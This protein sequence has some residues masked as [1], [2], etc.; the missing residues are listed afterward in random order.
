MKTLLAIDIGSYKTTAIIAEQNESSL[1]ISG[2]G[3]AKSRGI[4][5]GAIINIDEAAK[6]IKKA[7]SD[8]ER[9]AGIE[10]KEAI[11]S[12]SSTY[13]KSI[14]SHGIV[15]IPKN[16]ITKE[17]IDRVIQTA[18]Y[19]ATNPADYD[20]L[21]AIPYNFKVDNQTEI[22]DP[23]GM[24]GSRLEVDLHIIIAQ[25]NGIENIKK[26]FQ[27]AGIEI[28]A[29]VNSAYASSLAVLEEDEKELGVALIDIG[30]TTSD[31]AIFINKTIRYVDF[32]GIGS[33]HITND[34][35]IALHT[36][37]ADAEYIKVNF[38]ELIKENREYIEI[39]MIGS[40][41]K[42]KIS[43]ATIIQIMSARIEETFL[44]LNKEIDNSGNKHQING[45]VL[46]G[47]FTNFYN[48]REIASQFFDGLP[49]RVG[50]PKY[51]E[52]SF[53]KLQNPESSAVIGLLLYAIGENSK[54]ET[55][56]SKV[57]KKKKV[58]EVIVK[59]EKEEDVTDIFE[60][61]PSKKKEEV[62]IIQKFINWITNIF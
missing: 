2:V 24:N 34:L 45:I 42:Q 15:N 44:L 36:T 25:K 17:E 52:G 33:H 28:A 14:K 60:V 54:Y 10:A 22:D 51:I 3:I 47:G 59:E 43:L 19:N 7:V 13:T 39:S 62:G 23:L 31:L 32:L 11:V 4:K 5:R 46:T 40:D 26:T 16:E 57:T 30:A 58:E 9:I 38:Q 41:E 49:V 8:A 35:S 6:S 53:E 12:V 18:I 20:L 50:R 29:M 48:I 61:K 37:L 1:S 55:N 21:Q 27:K 56:P